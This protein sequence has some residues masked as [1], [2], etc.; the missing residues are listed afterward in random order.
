MADSQTKKGF[1][2]GIFGGKKRPQAGEEIELT[3]KGKPSDVPS[4][5]EVKKS[6]GK[7]KGITNKNLADGKIR[8]NVHPQDLVASDYMIDY[9][10][11]PFDILEQNPTRT[12]SYVESIV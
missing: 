5:Q 4:Q 6:K 10:D 2:A 12:T 7:S 9:K 1:L 11:N 8:L 3:V